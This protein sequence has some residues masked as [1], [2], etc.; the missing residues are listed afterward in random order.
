M[1]NKTALDKISFSEMKTFSPLFDVDIGNVFDVRRSLA[2]RRA[3]GAPSPKMSQ[4][5]SRAGGQIFANESP[6]GSSSPL[7]D[8]NSGGEAALFYHRP[9][10]GRSTFRSLFCVPF[11]I[12]PS[13]TQRQ[14]NSFERAAFCQPTYRGCDLSGAHTVTFAATA[15]DNRASEGGRHY[16]ADNAGWKNRP[17]LTGTHPAQ[18]RI[19]CFV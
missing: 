12:F 4:R 7:L 13:E 1:Q 3:I 15:V 8:A 11:I 2:E 10:S 14:G 19:R 17:H 6:G 9:R 18:N 16:R 5:R